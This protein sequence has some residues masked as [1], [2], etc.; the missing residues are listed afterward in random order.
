MNNMNIQLKQENKRQKISRYDSIDGARLIMALL[1][2]VLHVGMPLGFCSK[3]L[4]DIA[5]IA[6]PFSS[7]VQD[8]LYTTVILLLLERGLESL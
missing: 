8:F 3:Y 6:V 2:A 1:V 7:C 4:C 5:R